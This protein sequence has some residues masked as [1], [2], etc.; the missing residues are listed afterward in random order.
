MHIAV[1]VMQLPILQHSQTPL[2]CKVHNSKTSGTR[3][4]FVLS[5]LPRTLT[6]PTTYKSDVL[7]VLWQTTTSTTATISRTTTKADTTRSGPPLIALSGA[8]QGS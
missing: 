8:K 6:L 1:A 2:S 5:P 7:S 3:Q 4:G